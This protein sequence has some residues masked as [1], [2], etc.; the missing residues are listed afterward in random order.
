MTLGGSSRREQCCFS[1]RAASSQRG[2]C[3]DV[4]ATTAG[5][6]GAAGSDRARAHQG[7]MEQAEQE[8][9]AALEQGA[10]PS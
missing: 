3:P 2:K 6:G 7:L 10:A 9:M 8:L 1:Q 4:R 5:H